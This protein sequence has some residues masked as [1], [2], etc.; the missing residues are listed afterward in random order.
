LLGL[1]EALKL[2][3][4]SITVHADSELVIK[5]V[6][7]IYRVKHPVMQER[8]REAL[9]LLARFKT[10]RAVHVPREKNAEADRLANEALDAAN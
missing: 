9:S 7:G 4:E 2:G 10:W 1:Q 5:Q 3:A 8:H 6:N